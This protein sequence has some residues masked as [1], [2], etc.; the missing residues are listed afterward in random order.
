MQHLFQAL[1]NQQSDAPLVVEKI[2]MDG[3]GQH[4]FPET[5]HDIDVVL[6]DTNKGHI[7]SYLGNPNRPATQRSASKLGQAIPLIETGAADAM[8]LTDEQLALVCASHK[9]E[10]RHVALVRDMLSKFGVPESA[11][12][13]PSG[14][15][16]MCSGNHGNEVCTAVHMNEPIEGYYHANHPTQ[17]RITKTLQEMMGL[18]HMPAPVSDGCGI[19][20]HPVPLWAAAAMAARIAAPRQGP[21][22]SH[23][24]AI[25]RLAQAGLA[26]PVL[27][28]G[29]NYPEHLAME[30]L[31][32]RLYVKQ[33]AE[34]FMIM[35]DRAT[36]I[37][38][39]MRTRSGNNDIIEQTMCAIIAPELGLTATST[40]RLATLAQGIGTNT[41]GEPVV[42]LK[43]SAKGL[44]I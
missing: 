43:Y 16:H 41:V 3:N 44:N 22:T 4:G 15:A 42:R 19:P 38:L 8:R 26:N 17:Q 39:A 25:E 10:D 29:T 30:A 36:G 31:N 6:F 33:G 32:G 11:L 13:L 14:A 5:W 40:D 28:S 27:L 7:I 20:T 24:E 18:K 35:A 2:R 12:V 37:G 1:A 9:S 23:A 34:G 21:N